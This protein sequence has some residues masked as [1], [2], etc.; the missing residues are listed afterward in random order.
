MPVFSQIK[1]AILMCHWP[2]AGLLPQPNIV[3]NVLLGT[4]MCYTHG[5]RA[6]AGSSVSPWTPAEAAGKLPP[7]WLTSASTGAFLTGGRKE[8]CRERWNRAGGRRWKGG[9]R[10]G[11]KPRSGSYAG[12]HHTCPQAAQLKFRSLGP[13][14]LFMRHRPK[15]PYWIN[16]TCPT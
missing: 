4:S 6:N 8:G 14:L 5:C 12:Y 13:G 7:C 15:R 16:G 2:N 3:T 1:S 10:E 11:E 9:P